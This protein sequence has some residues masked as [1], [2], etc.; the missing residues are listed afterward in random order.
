M[1]WGDKQYMRTM[2][3]EEYRL[4]CPSAMVAQA[5]DSKRGRGAPGTSLEMERREGRG[6]ATLAGGRGAHDR[7][8]WDFPGIG[9]GE[10]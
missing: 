8:G 2:R 1:E 6:N 10:G 5:R 9:G 7:E 4:L 3:R